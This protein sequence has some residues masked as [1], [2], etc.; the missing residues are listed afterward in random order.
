MRI[1]WVCPWGSPIW[2]TAISS[3]RLKLKSSNRFRLFILQ[4]NRTRMCVNVQCRLHDSD[5]WPWSKL[6]MLLSCWSRYSLEEPGWLSY[7]LTGVREGEAAER[8]QPAEGVHVGAVAEP[9]LPL[10]ESVSGRDT[11]RLRQHRPHVQPSVTFF[12]RGLEVT[13]VVTRWCGASDQRGSR[14]SGGPGG[15]R[16]RTGEPRVSTGAWIHRGGM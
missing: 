7:A 14:R 1:G 11:S 6:L 5:I 15:V 16:A 8:A 12:W 13:Q 10:P 9:L 4:S 2:E 3:R